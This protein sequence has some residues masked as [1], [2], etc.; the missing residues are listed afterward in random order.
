M[1]FRPPCDPRRPLFELVGAP[2]NVCMR[3]VV[4][5]TPKWVVE[6]GLRAD[7]PIP[8]ILGGVAPPRR[9]GTSDAE[10]TIDSAPDES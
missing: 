5:P 9:R 1:P 6:G 4:R 2:S 10:A 8:P 7:G 3:W